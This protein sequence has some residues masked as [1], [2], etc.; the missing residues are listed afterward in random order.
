MDHRS[1]SNDSMTASL[2]LDPELF[3][4]SRSSGKPSTTSSNI[5]ND[6]L[7]SQAS[8]SQRGSYDQAMYPD[9]ENDFSAE[10]CSG[11]RKV[12]TGGQIRQIERKDSRQGMKRR[13]LSPPADVARDDKSSAYPTELYQKLPGSVPARSPATQHRP[14]PNYGSVSSTASSMRQGSYASSFVPSLAGSSLTSVS[15][16]ERQSPSDSTHL[17]FITSAYP[18]SSPATSIAPTRKATTQQPPGEN[19]EVSRPMSSQIVNN[20]ARPHASARSGLPLICD[21]CPKKPRKF[22][23]EDELR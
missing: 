21:C 10:E 11:L 23:T 12:T 6:G 1:P 5:G 7:A 8:Q 18:T 4:Q 9:A 22:D 13:A 14:F 19:T 16:Y 20:D 2:V 3:L 17:P 15:S